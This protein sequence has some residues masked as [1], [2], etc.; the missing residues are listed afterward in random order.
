MSEEYYKN[1]KEALVWLQQKGKISQGAFYGYCEQGGYTNKIGQF[2]PLVVRP[3]KT[4]SKFQVMQFA[5]DFFGT[6]KAISNEDERAADADRRKR[7]AEA[8]MAERKND[9][10]KRQFDENW[11]ERPKA[12]KQMAAILG[13]SRSAVLRRMHKCYPEIIR[14][15]GGD[16]T[17]GNEVYEYLRSVVTDGFNDICHAGR[18]EGV[19]T[20]EKETVEPSFD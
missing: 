14:R 19:L 9:R 2:Y 7:I 8:E 15:C 17:R 3:D 20:K 12:I 1:R 13:N 6:Q 18:V 11:L 10:E 4:I 5:M 16:H